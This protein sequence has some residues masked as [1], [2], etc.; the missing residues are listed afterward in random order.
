MFQFL[1]SFDC[2][3]PIVPT[4]TQF[5]P[6]VSIFFIPPDV[7]L[8]CS[9]LMPST[10]QTMPLFPPATISEEACIE[11]VA[12]QKKAEPVMLLAVNPEGVAKVLYFKPWVVAITHLFLK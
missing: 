10:D 8:L 3:M 6:L 5:E 9:Q 2:K 1:P 4:A 11:D 7:I 12:K